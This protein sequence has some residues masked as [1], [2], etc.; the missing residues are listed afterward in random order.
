MALRSP[1]QYRESLRDGRNVY[2]AGQR[3]EDVTTHPIMS[4]LVDHSA[5]AFQTPDDPEFRELWIARDEETDEPIS[6]YF[7]VPKTAED[8]RRRSLV[9][10]KSTARCRGMF[11]IVRAIGT[12]A[13]FAL[14]AT[15][16]RMDRELG[17]HYRER[18]EN[19]ARLCRRQDLAMVTAQT[20]V[21]G[22]RALRP[23]EQ[24]DPDLY[25]RI[26][27]RRSDGIVVRGA[28]AHTTQ[29]PVANEIVVIPTRVMTEKDADYAVAFA[30]PANARGVHMICRPTPSTRVRGFD[31]PLSRFDV[32]TESLTVFDD[33][34]VPWE[35]VFMAGEWQY[36]GMLALLFAT[37]HRFT[38]VSYKPPSLD[39]L[40]GVAHLVAEYN[41]VGTAA[42]VRTKIAELIAYAELVR[43][44]ALAAAAQPTWLDPPG[45]AVP[46]PVYTQAGKWHFANQYHEMVK[47]VQ[48][49]AGGL[50]TTAP[51]AADLDNPV[52]GPYIRKYL[53]G[54]GVDGAR[55]LHLM[56]LIRDMTASD[57]A[58][59]VEVG[60][61]HG[62]GSLQAQLLGIYRDYDF[63]RSRSLVQDILARSVDT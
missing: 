9:I 44:A 48:D 59:Y 7:V 42:H 6:R 24:A 58:G 21:K 11:N 36:A 13:L 20:D 27:E 31:R 28:K 63:S 54:A 60:T 5:E 1:E 56:N 55:R 46:N 16:D 17:T 14:L 41:G 45:I 4:I 50:A 2:V 32:E 26:V 37:F 47:L 15:A 3:V 35:R 43:A 38:A 18:V 23:H 22:N 49:I 39:A 10:E 53:A 62:E 8:L 29:G 33:V 30:V 57:F 51:T 34:F 61:V 52:T 25:V 19:Y 12:D 40:V